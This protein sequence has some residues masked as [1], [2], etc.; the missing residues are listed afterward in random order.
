MLTSSQLSDLF[1]RLDADG[2][3]ELDYSEFKRI[4]EK[5]ELDIDAQVI[6]EIFKQVDVEK[7]GTLSLKEFNIAYTRV[8][9]HR[10]NSKQSADPENVGDL[11]RATRYGKENG[12]YFVEEWVGTTKVADGLFTKETSKPDATKPNGVHI[13]KV[14]VPN[15]TLDKINEMMLKDSESN[16]AMPKKH[17]VF[18]WVDVAMKYVGDTSVKSVI[19]TFDLPNHSI[20]EDVYGDFGNILNK[21]PKHRIFMDS[22]KNDTSVLSFFVQALYIKGRPLQYLLPNFLDWNTRGDDLYTQW[23]IKPAKDYYATRLA[24]FFSSPNAHGYNEKFE[25]RS[26]L[27]SAEAL[28]KRVSTAD[29]LEVWEDKY[30]LPI[31]VNVP[32][33]NSEPIWLTNTSLLRRYPPRIEYASLGIHMIQPIGAAIPVGVV[34]IRQLD[35]ER[36]HKKTKNPSE[37]LAALEEGSRGGVMG[38]MLA[39][40]RHR[41][42]VLIARKEGISGDNIADH[43]CALVTLLVGMTHNFSM[44]TSGALDEW[45]NVLQDDAYDLAVSKHTEHVKM[46]KSQIKSINDYIDPTRDLLLE[47]RGR[48]LKLDESEISNLQMQAVEPAAAV[49]TQVSKRRS[50]LLKNLPMECHP[51]LKVFLGENTVETLDKVRHS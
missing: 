4:A 42:H 26:A 2:S 41:I 13:T 24:W 11:V 23:I 35:S 38:R 6:S 8:F 36:V 28:A 17:Q 46:V 49:K 19:D 20:I 9:L 3:G 5:L 30:S 44:N 40:V 47:M 27:E 10:A 29:P 45:L 51:E 32:T 12:Q 18:W 50:A 22:G 43:P 31:N 21:D 37:M 7:T 39:G 48:A 14:S 34:S 1:R 33:R 15:I 25:L 16:T